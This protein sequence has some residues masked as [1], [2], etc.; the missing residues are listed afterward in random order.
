VQEEVAAAINNA[1]NNQKI[2]TYLYRQE[3]KEEK[4]TNK[5]V[6][7]T[8]DCSGHQAL[9]PTFQFIVPNFI[10]KDANTTNTLWNL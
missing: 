8:R 3:K 1:K 2:P 6:K 5:K 9:F 7:K 4:R 10:L